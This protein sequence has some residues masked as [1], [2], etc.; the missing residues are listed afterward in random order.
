LEEKVQQHDEVVE[1]GESG[2][3]SQA[4]AHGE[5]SEHEP[6][7]ICD[8]YARR[9]LC[10]PNIWGGYFAHS[11]QN[12]PLKYLGHTSEIAHVNFTT[13]PHNFG[14]Q[15]QVRKTPL[16]SPSFPYEI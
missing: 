6:A 7:L 10:A 3:M 2:C 14:L 1:S 5:A 4:R 8:S 16:P 11:Q 12:S 9:I 15:H 13:P